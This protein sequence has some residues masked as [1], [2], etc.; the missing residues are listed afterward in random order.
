MPLATGPFTAERDVAALCRLTRALAPRLGV[1]ERDARGLA[2]LI[3]ET[4]RRLAAAGARGDVELGVCDGPCLQIEFRAKGSAEIVQEIEESLAPIRAMAGALSIASADGGATIRARVPITADPAAPLPVLPV[5]VST[6][7]GGRELGAA[8]A[9]AASPTAPVAA[10]PS[11]ADLAAAMDEADRHIAGLYGDLAERAGRLE[12]VQARCRKMEEAL[13][14]R[15]EELAAANR[16]T[17]DFLSTLSHELRTPLNAML[18]WARLLRLGRLDEAGAAR[19]L[20]ALER[21]ARAQACLI[22]D[23]LDASRIVTGQLELDLQPTW[24]AGIVTAV[25]DGMRSD[26]DAKS[27][28]LETDVRLGGRVRADPARLEQVVRNLL[29]N[30]IKFTPEGGRI[31]VS[32]TQAGGEAMLVVADTGEGID[33]AFLPFVFERFRH[34]DTSPTRPHRGLGLGL[35]IVRHIVELHD[36]RVHVAS[37]GPGRGASFAVH[38][39]IDP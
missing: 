5:R 9:A 18:G 27:I 2:A 14:R 15:A 3:G 1:G 32:L 7:P 36:G 17:E 10:E 34:A 37:E 16:A 20:D 26:A 23:I 38:L 6:L 39:P 29:G 12:D 8:V 21:N 30:G 13:N 22:A 19:A 11:A 28:T 4:A 31:R 33:Q 35:S 24:L 25:V